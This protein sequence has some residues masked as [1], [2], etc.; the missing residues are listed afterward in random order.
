[1][2]RKACKNSGLLH[3]NSNRNLYDTSEVLFASQL[4]LN[5]NHTDVDMNKE[6]F[7]N[8]HSN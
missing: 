4:G 2:K 5:N 7:W 8:V 6:L 1:M 3:Q